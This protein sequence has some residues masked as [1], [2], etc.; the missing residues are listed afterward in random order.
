MKT[1][2][3]AL[4]NKSSTSD[5]SKLTKKLQNDLKKSL[6]ISS[7]SLSFKEHNTFIFLAADNPLK[8]PLDQETIEKTEDRI[9]HHLG[10]YY[11]NHKSNLRKYLETKQ[12]LR[13]TAQ[14]V[15]EFL[16]EIDPKLPEVF[17]SRLRKAT[18]ELPEKH[19][20][21]QKQSLVA[22]WDLSEA[23]KVRFLLSGWTSPV[24]D[25]SEVKEP[26]NLEALV[27]KLAL[28]NFFW[29]FIQPTVVRLREMNNVLE[30]LELGLQGTHY[31]SGN[32]KTQAKLEMFFRILSA[33]LSALQNVDKTISSILELF[34]EP[35]LLSSQNGL[36]R[37]SDKLKTSLRQMSWKIN[38]GKSLLFEVQDK[39][40]ECQKRL[41]EYLDETENGV[42]MAKSMEEFRL[43]LR[44]MAELSSDLFVEAESL[45]MWLD[46]FG[47]DLP[48]F[49]YQTR[50]F[51]DQ[52]LQNMETSKEYII[53][54]RGLAKNYNL[55]RT[56]V[57]ALRG[58]DLDIKEGEFVA[59][60]GNSGAGKTTLLNCIA[61]LDEPDYGIVLFKGKNLH[62]MDDKEKS[63][64]RLIDMGF[65]FQSYA[66]LPHYN[67]RENVALPA[68]LAGLSRNL[69]SRIEELL[70]G[71]GIS[72]QATQYPAQL[73]GGQ[74]Q[75]VA[76]ARALTNR[77][78]VLFAD[79]PTG[80]LD[81]ETGKQVM[82][83][84]KK[85]HEET[86]TT[87]IIITHEQSVADYAERQIIMEDGKIKEAKSAYA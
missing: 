53:S 80:D 76:I 12:E 59:I 21:L 37:T 9:S 44:P 15:K 46:F 41:Q 77:P 47:T 30:R 36:I 35:Q 82:E 51:S 4:I 79:E 69:K 14:I 10:E 60:V 72:K 61:G 16:E 8:N 64:T 85:F 28:F 81:S 2:F 63:N 27:D 49:T 19:Y 23:Q 58:L 22:L 73:S 3:A 24:F 5:N 20:E 54:V 71:V 31:R 17:N 48:Y 84:I 45:K 67:T 29:I 32:P 57:Y 74:M 55:G 13:E 38:E 33:K 66:L 18:S 52:T 68:D 34:S 86:K 62:R 70:E 7:S 11:L 43:S 25:I 78:K 65:I 50:L 39:L 56:R 6:K 40:E 87:V 1:Y 42:K 75:R 26:L 83:L